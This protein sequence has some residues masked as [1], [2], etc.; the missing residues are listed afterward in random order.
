MIEKCDSSNRQKRI[1][2]SFS[3]IARV[4]AKFELVFALS[5]ENAKRFLEV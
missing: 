4:K 1:V 5:Q 3:I 2:A